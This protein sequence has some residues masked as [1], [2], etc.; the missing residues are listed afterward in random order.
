MTIS[1]QRPLHSPHI[2]YVQVTGT[3]GVDGCADKVVHGSCP[4]GEDAHPA[5]G[6][7]AL[8]AAATVDEVPTLTTPL[9][10]FALTTPS[11]RY[12]LQVFMREDH[13]LVLETLRADELGKVAVKIQRVESLL[14]SSDW[15]HSLPHFFGLHPLTPSFPRIADDARVPHPAH[16]QEAAGRPQEDSG[17]HRH[18][19]HR[20]HRGRSS[21]GHSRYTLIPPLDS[22]TSSFPHIHTPTLSFPHI[23]SPSYSFPHIHYS[24][25]HFLILL[26]PPSLFLTLMHTTPHFLAHTSSF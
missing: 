16:L 5:A 1:I 3:R 20:C 6:E 12:A 4:W 8:G 9:H 24:P 19:H 18:S 2:G 14:F 10:C 26:H 23:D 17:C 7:T 25:S 22:H 13:R 11:H 15:I 21:D